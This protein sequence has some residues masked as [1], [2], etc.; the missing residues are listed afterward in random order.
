MNESSLEKGDVIN[1]I[2]KLEILDL[3]TVAF[4]FGP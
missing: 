3:I 4:D 2:L 1:T